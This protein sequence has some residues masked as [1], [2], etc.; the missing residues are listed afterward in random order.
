MPAFP[1]ANDPSPRRTVKVEPQQLAKEIKEELQDEEMGSYG[2]KANITSSKPINVQDLMA[3][4]GISYPMLREEDIKKEES[5]PLVLRLKRREP[6]GPSS[7]FSSSQLPIPVAFQSIEKV[8]LKRT[9][10]SAR[11]DCFAYDN[12]EVHDEEH[13]SSPEPASKN[14]RTSKPE[15]CRCEYIVPELDSKMDRIMDK[16]SFIETLAKSMLVKEETIIL[17]KSQAKESLAK[18]QNEIQQLRRQLILQRNHGLT[19]PD[20]NSY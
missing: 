4:S 19:R 5:P 10:K 16:M 12:P 17:E 3:S 14:K 1:L 18:A 20:N 8:N 15:G 11:Q 6:D 2:A 9:R 7:S 13:E